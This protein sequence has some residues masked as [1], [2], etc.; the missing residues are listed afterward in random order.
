MYWKH[1]VFEVLQYTDFLNKQAYMNH[2][3]YIYI[4]KDLIFLEDLVFE[5]RSYGWNLQVL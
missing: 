1:K 2:I 3:P 4:Y 5:D